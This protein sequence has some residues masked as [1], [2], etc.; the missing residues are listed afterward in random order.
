MSAV[1]DSRLRSRL[2]ECV[3]EEVWRGVERARASVTQRKN[4]AAKVPAAG[5]QLMRESHEL[6]TR[7]PVCDSFRFGVLGLRSWH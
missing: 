4:E 1:V 7:A 5:R 2:I 6:P 3:H